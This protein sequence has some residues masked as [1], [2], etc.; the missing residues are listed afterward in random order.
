MNL[1]NEPPREE[2]IQ[3]KRNTLNKRYA[4]LLIEFELVNQQINETND[5]VEVSRLQEK[6]NN[7]YTKLEK[8]DLDLKQIDTK[9]MTPNIRYL[10]F[11]QDLPKIDFNEIMES[12][13][14]MIREFRRGA[15][16]DALLLIQESLAMGGDLCIRRIQERLKQETGDFKHIEIEFSPEGCLDKIGFLNKLADYF[17]ISF[18]KNPEKF[19]Q[20]FIKMIIGKIC[21]SLQGGSILFLEVRK[22][23]ELTCQADI[24]KW[25]ITEFW[26]PLVVCLE[27]ISQTYRRVKFIGAIIA[28]TEF[29]SD[30]LD[31]P[32]FCPQEN[33]VRML[34]LPLK[35][36]TV[37]EI[38]DWLE[39][40]PGLHNPRSIQ[41]ANRIYKASKKGFPA[42]VYTA[43]MREFIR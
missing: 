1:N 34:L 28:D 2:P 14:Q 12:I 27:N 41:L 16:G 36:W 43:L 8:I 6:A 38:Q 40:Y 9:S 13:D 10:S 24:F 19:E 4:K 11:E 17:N 33:S 35:N 22:W 26:M 32:C 25:F 42:M 3:I 18:A 31:L 21:S 7:L 15:R 20:E 5:E 23:D 30:S 29:S 37:D 39:C